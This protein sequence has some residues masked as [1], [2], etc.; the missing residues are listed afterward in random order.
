M[1]QE[2]KSK[3]AIIGGGPAGCICAYFLQDDFEVTIFDKKSPLLT[4]LPTGG[5]RC[6]LAHA[7]YDFR[8]LAKNYPRGEKFLYSVFSKFGT[9]DTIEFFKKIAVPTYIQDDMRFFPV[10]NSAKDVREKFLKALNKVKF[11]KEEVLRINPPQT[12]IC[13]SEHTNLRSFALAQ[14]DKCEESHNNQIIT[15][16]V[17]NMGVYKSD[18]VVIATGGHASF[19]LIRLLGHKIIEPKPALTGLVTKEDLSKLS[20]V[21]FN[22]VLFTHKGISGPAVYKISSLRA[23]DKFPYT[24]S[25][26]FVGDIDLQTALNENPHKSIKNLLADYVPKS[27]AEFILE[28]PDKKCHLIN[29]KTRDK[30][31]DKLQNFTVTAIGTVPD[32]EVVTSGGVD[33]K[34]INPKTMESKLVPQVYF[35][36]EVMD[37]DGFCGGFN[38]QNCWSTGFVASQAIKNYKDNLLEI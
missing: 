35:C 31:L 3:V 9:A 22:D 10:S 23:R 6:N 4:L 25:F 37:I 1:A 11:V 34:E 29:G 8:E 24:L 18:F 38:L 2:Q 27:F 30:I 36:G 19:E 5:G 28:E 17:T 13:H 7:E 12:N 26:N 33:L 20:G 21:S 32:G 15:S 14:D 16:I